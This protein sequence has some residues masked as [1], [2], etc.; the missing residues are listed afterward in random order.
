MRRMRRRTR[1]RRRRG[2]GPSRLLPADRG[3]G[4]GPTHIHGVPASRGGG[5]R[6]PP[7]PMTPTD[8]ALRR[9]VAFPRPMTPTD[10][11]LRRCS[12]G[13]SPAGACGRPPARRCRCSRSCV[14]CRHPSF[15]CSR[16]CCSSR[17]PP[18]PPGRRVCDCCCCCCCT[19]RTRR[20]ERCSRRESPSSSLRSRLCTVDLRL[21]PPGCCWGPPAGRN[22]A[23]DV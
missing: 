19:C 15:V 1:T 20:A 8:S 6:H 9:C 18:P 10:S 23:V 13:G 7:C 17:Q 11:A 12:R 21:T 22:G 2:G 4:G 14:E 5:V 16:S 3:R